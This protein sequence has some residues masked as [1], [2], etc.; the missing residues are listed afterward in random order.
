LQQLPNHRDI[1]FSIVQAASAH[2]RAAGIVQHPGVLP[3][4]EVGT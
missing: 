4:K 1:Y 3:G 2:E